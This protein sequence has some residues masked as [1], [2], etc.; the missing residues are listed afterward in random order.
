MSPRLS[1]SAR[2]CIRESLC[3]CASCALASASVEEGVAINRKPPLGH[4]ALCFSCGLLRSNVLRLTTC[5]RRLE[6]VF[7]NIRGPC[8]GWFPSCFPSKEETIPEREPPL[9]VSPKKTFQQV[10]P[11]CGFP[12]KPKSPSSALLPL[13]GGGFP[14]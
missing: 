11:P 6:K 10:I 14:Y 7:L 3:L 13:F 4:W 2:L 12:L 8:G 9:L 1:A 5:G